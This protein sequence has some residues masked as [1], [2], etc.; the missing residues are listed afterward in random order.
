AAP[1]PG[2]PGAPFSDGPLRLD[3]VYP[4]AD[5][6]ITSRDS[7]FI[8]GSTGSGRAALTING[9]PVRVAANGAFL[10][11]VPV[12]PDGI[13]RITATREAETARAEHRIRVPAPPSVAPTGAT[14]VP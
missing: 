5:A 13:Y 8:F 12:P 2:L 11:F 3:V 4:P 9:A 6:I 14:I 1:T 10:A 7:N